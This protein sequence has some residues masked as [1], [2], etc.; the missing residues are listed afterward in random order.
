MDFKTLSKTLSKSLILN[1][2]ILNLWFLFPVDVV[3]NQKSN[4]YPKN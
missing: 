3:K 1:L 2:Q 4:I